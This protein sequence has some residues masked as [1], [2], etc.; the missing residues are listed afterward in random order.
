MIKEY[1]QNVPGGFA[2]TEIERFPYHLLTINRR[3][4]AS[5]PLE[6]R[7]MQS[8]HIIAQIGRLCSE[9]FRAIA[10]EDHP[11]R[12]RLPVSLPLGVVDAVHA[13]RHQHAVQPAL[14][15]NGQAHVTVVEERVPL[16]EQYS[17]GLGIWQQ[18]SRP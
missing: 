3:I 15:R 12:L 14:G 9:S 5:P 10:D 1:L 17:P 2:T 6:T 18:R 4:A 7:Q 8:I 16:E 11:L 13:R